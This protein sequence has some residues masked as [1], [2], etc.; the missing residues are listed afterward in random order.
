MKY[1]TP[2]KS[3]LLT[4]IVVFHCSA[5]WAVELGDKAPD[6]TLISNDGGSISL[7]KFAGKVVYLDVWASWCSTCIKSLKWMN[8]LQERYGS[9][10]F[11]VL[12]V[13]VD[14]NRK[15][16]EKALAGAASKILVA[17]DPQG[18]TPQR[19]NVSAMPTSFLIGRD[20][21]LIAV[22]SGLDDE[23]RKEIERQ[24]EMSLKSVSP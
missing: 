3:L 16:A 9:E 21:S 11:Q 15:D 20:G 10:Q 5:L 6:F 13:N 17:F 1:S 19:L 23:A 22:H 7:S 8:Q 2:L 18:I 14:E 24:I 4:L 12:A